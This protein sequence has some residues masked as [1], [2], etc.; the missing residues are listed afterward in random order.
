MT[1]RC[2]NILRSPLVANIS[3]LLSA[4]VLAQAIG[5]LIYPLLTR[6]F[7]ADDFGLFNLF[8][9]IGG[10]VVLFAT[11]QYEYA[12]V[13]PRSHRQ[14]AWCLHGGLAVSA[15]VTL[16]CL[17][18]LPFARPIAS[19]FDA[20]ALADYLWLMPLYVLALSLWTLLNYWLSRHECFNR[21]SAY[22]VDQSLLSAGVKLATGKFRV[23]GGLIYGS[24]A[25]PLVALL[26]AACRMPRRLWDDLRQPD[27]RGILAAMRRYRN[28]PC[29][30]LPKS[31][32]DS[33]SSNLPLLLM[34]PAFGLPVVGYLG[35]ALTLAFRP[36][37]IICSSVNQVFY[38]RAATLVQQRQ[39]PCRLCC[40]Y[41][42]MAT[43]VAVPSF[44]LL[45]WWLPDLCGWLLGDGWNVTGEYI[46]I[47]LPWL[48]LVL[49]SNAI[50]FIPDL[51][52][53]QRGL[54]VFS[55]VRLAV[56]AAALLVGISTGSDRSTVLLFFGAGSLVLLSQLVWF[57]SLLKGHQRLLASGR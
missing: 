13:L 20:P 48:L 55:M 23:A 15:V 54:M 57:F 10:I 39:S 5:L 51:F 56:Q 11:A 31:V 53:R 46:R 30:T 38:Q 42:L 6:L 52:G 12:I 14:A 34:A 29:F 40:R 16:L 9:S 1:D 43:A 19:L 45:Y 27:R 17:L 37:N 2:R 50:N 7:S 21:V 22:Q 26:V 47:M 8:L 18:A 24:V 35:M 36:I 33:L 44:A 28:F 25:A 32:V 41:A 3:R 4:N 49:V